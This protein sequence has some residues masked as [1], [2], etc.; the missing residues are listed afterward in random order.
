MRQVRLAAARWALGCGLLPLLLGLPAPP[1][2]LTPTL[3]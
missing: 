3:T 2:T 1:L